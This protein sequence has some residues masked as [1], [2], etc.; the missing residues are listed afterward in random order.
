MMVR[1]FETGIFDLV[2]LGRYLHHERSK[3][4]ECDACEGKEL[5]AGSQW[6]KGQA[7]A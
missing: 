3:I 2:V 1:V 7:P 6:H 5:D 4:R